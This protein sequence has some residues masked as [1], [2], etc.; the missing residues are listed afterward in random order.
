MNTSTLERP[1]TRSSAKSVTADLV[2]VPQSI[3]NLYFYGEPRAEDR[4]WVMIDAGVSPFCESIVQAAADYFGPQSRPE[5]IILTHGHF[6]HVGALPAIAERWDVPVYAHELELPYLDGRSKYPPPDPTVGGGAM[7][8]LSRLYPRGPINLGSRLRVL[9]SDG[10]VP[11]MPGWQW[12]HTPGHTAGHVA[13]FREADRTLIAGD[14]FVT[15]QQESAW[16]VL[17]RR[18]EVCR[19][20]AYY[21]TDWDAARGSVEAL[22]ELRPQIAATGH[23][24]PMSGEKLLGQLEALLREWDRVA[25][26]PR[27][28]YVHHPA[29]TDNQGVVSVPPPVTDYKLLAMVGLGLFLTAGS[30][31]L[32]KRG[33][34]T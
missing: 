31:L 22:F 2:R 16:A 14:A 18:Q 4:S 24:I 25:V 30:L 8:F 9:P 28:R 15:Q 21:T 29:I 27:G 17:T 12:I 34:G 7:S 10:S 23:G 26:P 32:Y 5:A 33:K 20:P 1:F 19:P 11:G 13:F 6:D 3:V